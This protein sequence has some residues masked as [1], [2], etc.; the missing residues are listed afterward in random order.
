MTSEESSEGHVGVC[1]TVSQRPRHFQNK[2]LGGIN[3][4][5]LVPS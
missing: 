1:L 2:V 3:A 5:N 4:I